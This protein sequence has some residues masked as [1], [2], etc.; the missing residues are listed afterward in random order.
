MNNHEYLY[1]KIAKLLALVKMF[2]QIHPPPTPLHLE[3]TPTRQ[4]Y[5]CEDVSAS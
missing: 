1:P 5:T 4:E 2:S 3:M